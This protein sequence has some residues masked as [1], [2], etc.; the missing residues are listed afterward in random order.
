ME[1]R[2]G[3]RKVKD[4]KCAESICCGAPEAG[5]SV[6]CQGR[7]S[8]KRKIEGLKGGRL[9]SLSFVKLSTRG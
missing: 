8:L 5:E 2:T 7:K 4:F 9:S 3:K 6:G 1:K